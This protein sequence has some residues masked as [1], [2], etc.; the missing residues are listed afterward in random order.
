VENRLLRASVF[1]R[2]A[3]SAVYLATAVFNPR[4]K[5][6]RY[7]TIEPK[8]AQSPKPSWPRYRSIMG[9]SRKIET[10]WKK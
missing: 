1:S 7:P 4:L 8:I 3:Y 9:V 5:K 2:A 10:K 6:L